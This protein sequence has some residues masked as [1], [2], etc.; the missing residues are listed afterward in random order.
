MAAQACPIGDASSAARPTND[1]TM[2]AEVVWRS[3]GE[4]PPAAAP[5]N[6]RRNL[7]GEVVDTQPLPGRDALAGT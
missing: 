5:S 7:C 2:S 1:E 4:K 3:G 6:A